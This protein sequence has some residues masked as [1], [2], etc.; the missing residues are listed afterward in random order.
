MEN[1]TRALFQALERRGLISQK[2]RIIRGFWTLLLLIS[3]TS[4]HTLFISGEA[5][6]R[7]RLPFQSL[8]SPSE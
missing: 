3:L 8:L 5:A 6:S 2:E 7:K 1:V 4:K